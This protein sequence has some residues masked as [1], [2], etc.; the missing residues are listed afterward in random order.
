MRTPTEVLDSLEEAARASL[1]VER[2][3]SGTLRLDAEYLPDLGRMSWR[4]NGVVDD[5]EQCARAIER[6]R[7]QRGHPLF[8]HVPT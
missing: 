8:S 4:I 5:R 2:F 7:T 6:A 3:I 1:N